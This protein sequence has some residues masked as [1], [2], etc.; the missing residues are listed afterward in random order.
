MVMDGVKLAM[1][2]KKSGPKPKDRTGMKFNHLTFLSPVTTHRWML[3]CDCGSVVERK[4]GPIVSGKVRSCGCVKANRFVPVED[5]TGQKF[6]LLTCEKYQPGGDW[7]C[8]CDCGNTTTISTHRIKTGETKSCGCWHSEAA[9]MRRFKHGESQKTR[10]NSIWNSMKARCNIPSVKS[11][12]RYGARGIKICREWESFV[13]FRDWALANGYADNLT[14]DRIDNDGSYSPENCRWV[15]LRENVNNQTKTRFVQ[16]QDGVIARGLFCKQFNV[17]YGFVR[18]RHEKG[19]SGEQ[20]LEEW[21][22]RQ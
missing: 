9:R 20:I 14:I 11:Y 17:K 2:R 4:A 22:K 19:F 3:K 18:S 16:Y 13:T 12:P 8:R 10:L 21:G 6:N 5:L 1:E 7:L 15:T